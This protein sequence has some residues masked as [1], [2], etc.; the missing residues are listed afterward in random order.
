MRHSTGPEVLPPLALVYSGGGPLATAV[1]LGVAAGLTYG[2]IDVSRVPALGT[3]G[4]AWAAAAGR[5]G[6]THEQVREVTR[7]V[8]LPDLRPGRLLHAATDLFGERRDDQLHTSV[9]RVPVAKRVILSGADHPVAQIVAAS[10]AVPLM[11]FPVWVDGHP[12][13]DGGTR[14]WVSA[15][16][17][18]SA[19]RLIVVAPGITPSFGSWGVLLRRHLGVE[20]QRWKRRTGGRITVIRTTDE[21][22]RRV[23]RWNDLFDPRLA[24]EAHA[25][26]RAQVAGEL[27]AGGRLSD[28]VPANAA[29]GAVDP[30]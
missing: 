14:S 1:G 19:S 15:D 23:R 9:T 27:V 6:L 17:A 20:L 5:A 8:K 18:P 30:S 13:I 26:A 10:S 4:G 22:G 3:S 16:L 25:Q 7:Q 29:I 2:G 24:A 28:L 21:I 12:Y 11:A